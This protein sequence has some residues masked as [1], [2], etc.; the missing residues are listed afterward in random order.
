MSPLTHDTGMKI[1]GEKSGD[2]NDDTG[3]KVFS[4]KVQYWTHDNFKIN[5]IDE[6]NIDNFLM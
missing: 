2:R 3:M 6:F 5:I 4:I 1:P